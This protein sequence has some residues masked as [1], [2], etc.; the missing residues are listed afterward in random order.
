[1]KY[2]IL[3]CPRCKC[4]MSLY[5]YYDHIMSLYGH[6][7]SRKQ[8]TFECKKCLI[9][10]IIENDKILYLRYYKYG[11]IIYSYPGHNYILV[12]INNFDFRIES[13]VIDFEN[14]SKFF[15]LIK[16]HELLS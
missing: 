2:T 9:N 3:N 14:E 6:Y 7:N 5:D 13:F 11:Y 8:N 10:I 15:N 1:M 16:S 12:S 4:I